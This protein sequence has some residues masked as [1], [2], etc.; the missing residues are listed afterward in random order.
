MQ[1]CRR[2]RRSGGEPRPRQGRTG[3]LGSRVGERLSRDLC[4]IQFLRKRKGKSAFA[5]SR[6]LLGV[7]E[8]DLPSVRASVGF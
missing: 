7:Q 8:L 4:L 6:V 1:S 5:F 3:R 2:S